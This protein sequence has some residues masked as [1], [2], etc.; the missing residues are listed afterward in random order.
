M[1]SCSL[2]DN[3]Y[4][5]RAKYLAK[6]HML[7]QHSGFAWKCQRCKLL[8]NRSTSKHQCCKDGKLP[9]MTLVRRA[10]MTSGP[11]VDDEYNRFLRSTVQ[12]IT[13]VAG[14]PNQSTENR[15]ISHQK[16]EKR[17]REIS[18][19]SLEVIDSNK[20]QRIDD[21]KHGNEKKEKEESPQKVEE[22]QDKERLDK[23]RQEKERQERRKKKKRL[24]KERQEK[25]RQEKERQ[26]KER[27]EKERQE[28]ERQEKERQEKERQEKERQEKERQ[29]K[30]TQ[31][32][33]RQEK[34]TQEKER[35]E[36]ERQEKERQE[37]ER[38]EKERQEKERQD[39]E[40]QEERQE[41]RKQQEER[42]QE[43]EEAVIQEKEREET[44]NGDMNQLEID[45]LGEIEEVTVTEEQV[46]RGSSRS[47]SRDSSGDSR[48]RSSSRGSSHG[49]SRERS[50]SSS[51]RTEGAV[52]RDRRMEQLRRSQ[53]KR[54]ILNVGG[55]RFETSA[56]TLAEV[57]N[58]LLHR[59]VQKKLG[60]KPYSVEGVYTYF[61]D[62]DYSHFR[63]ILNYYRNRMRVN[64]ETLPTDI[65][66]LREL[67]M[68]ADYYQLS[69]LHDVLDLRISSLL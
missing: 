50:H 16:T 5:F 34:E 22:R 66:F 31:E 2:C 58:S 40:R 20:V 42:R 62:R 18:R 32:K 56:T 52:V 69:H 68:E 3:T 6:R 17:K 39:K 45:D 51:S 48:S 65:H 21:G 60:I 4:R 46:S 1:F 63:F 19:E 33:E 38:Q 13:T 8:F 54:I 14:K 25:E 36:K 41:E 29:E 61:I 59:M 28:K 35:Q 9:E 12:L 10:D 67:Q 57:P 27:Q 7:E 30:E 47:S 23:E 44:K 11:G 49:S 15:T 55:K 37:K 26:G 64:M 53:N 24:E 43:I